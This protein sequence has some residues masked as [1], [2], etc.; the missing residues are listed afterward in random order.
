MSQIPIRHLLTLLLPALLIGG[1]T[2]NN[3]SYHW[4]DLAK[5]VEK[6]NVYAIQE[7]QRNGF[8]PRDN[9]LTPHSTGGVKDPVGALEKGVARGDALSQARM[10][11]YLL[12]GAPHNGQSVRDPERALQLAKAARSNT[13]MSLRKTAAPGRSDREQANISAERETAV[14]FL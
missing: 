13:G 12:Y 6:G 3:P 10:A 7:M 4:R 5:E 14:R 11:L 1:C 8:Q 9:G 2:T